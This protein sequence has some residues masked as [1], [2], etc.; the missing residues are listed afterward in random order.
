MKKLVILMVVM[1]VTYGVYAG[2]KRSF[3]NEVVASLDGKEI[4]ISDLNN[5]VNTILGEKYAKLLETK[6]GLKQLAD[7]YITRKILLEEAKKTISSDN[8]LVKGH[9]PKGSDE[10]TMLLTALLD[11]EVNKKV[12]ITDEELGSFMLKNNITDR[13][14]AFA[15]LESI[16]R[17]EIFESYKEEI[18]K[19][20]KITN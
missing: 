6:E 1:I 2:A 7:Y 13:T 19:R 8:M 9:I 11:R 18:T 5:Y 4:T 12:V 17:N 16:K 14:A 20:H 10:D 15:R 3:S